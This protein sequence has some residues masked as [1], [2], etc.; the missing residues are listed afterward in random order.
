[1]SCTT[2]PPGAPLEEE[3]H[4]SYT[5]RPYLEIFDS[6]RVCKSAAEV[7]FS[8][9]YPELIKFPYFVDTTESGHRGWNRGWLYW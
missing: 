6:Q 8:I 9:S 7:Y 1:M 2:S 5:Y 4:Q 3:I